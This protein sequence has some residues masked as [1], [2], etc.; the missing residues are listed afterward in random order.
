MPALPE[1]WIAETLYPGWGQ[2]FLVTRELARVHS[3]FQEIVIFESLS[4]GRVV[5]LDG[6]VQIT[7]ADEFA[8]QE[9]IAHVP[10]I[11]HGAARRVLIIGAGDGGVLRRVLQHAGVERAVMVEIDGEVMR[12]VREHMPSI[13]AGAWEDR[14]AEIIT[15]D[16]IDY[17]A[18]APSSA[19]DVIIVDSTDPVGPGE[20]LFTEAFYRGCNRVLSAEGMIVN[21][22][23]APFMQKDELRETTILRAK[24]FK[25]V[26][27]Y[28]VAAP[29]YVG[30]FMTLG[31]ACKA[32]FN[33]ISPH[34]SEQ[35]A[36]S[37]GILGKTLY[38]SSDIQS[39]C[40]ALPPYIRC[41]LPRGSSGNHA[42]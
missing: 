18:H 33:L 27:A 15:G 7:E 9:M 13:A 29:T 22:C 2:R 10:M 3:P 1:E 32:N 25:C 36:S 23:G 41:L 14:R 28:I 16:G 34:E 6:V 4:H 8:Y 35:R 39:A 38:W 21:Q 40:F 26:S 11:Q 17:V 5:L 24:T 12:L 42:D 19:F 37:A 30:G 20:A 31:I